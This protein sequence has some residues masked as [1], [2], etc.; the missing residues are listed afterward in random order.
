MGAKRQVQ[1]AQELGAGEID[2]RYRP[3]KK[4]DEPDAVRVIG[5]DPD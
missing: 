1:L 3:K 4:D 5:Q 2:L